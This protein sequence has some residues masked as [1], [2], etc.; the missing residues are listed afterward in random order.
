V[1]FSDIKTRTK[2]SV[3]AGVLGIFCNTLLFVLKICVGVATSSIAIIS[4]AFNNLSDTGTSVVS[5]IGAKLSSKK[6]DKEHPFGHG[7]IEYI[8]SLIV[9]FIILLVGFELLK[10]SFTKIFTPKY[11]ALNPVLLLILCTSI[12]IKY[13]MYSYNKYLGKK[14][15]SGVLIAT[16]RDCINDVIA[17]SA[18][19]LSAVL[20]NYFKI[21]WLDGVTGIVVS[22]VIM[23]A[24]LKIAIDTSGLLL[25]SA[26]DIQTVDTIRDYVLK[27]KGIVGVH[28]L[29]IHD[30]GPGRR[31]A[32]VHAEVPDNCNISEV[33]ELVDQLEH[34]IDNELGINIVV[35]IDPITIDCEITNKYRELV[36]NVIKNIDKRMDIHDFRMTNGETLINLIFDVEIPYEYDDV[37]A[38]K[39]RIS[40]DV[41]GL[42][43]RLNT[44]INIDYI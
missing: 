18:V 20:T 4:D 36:K 34:K 12:P 10:T 8:S 9:S 5:I 2:C 37:Q 7:R 40:K 42:D 28:D 3:L 16:A 30:Y 14:I 13:L 31:L 23:Y 24:G 43:S 32:S 33:H 26:P 17:T 27:T 1:N 38:L 11:V 29:I 21:L 15:N 19:I 25:G 41:N 35:H 44:V 22:F 6:P 39:N